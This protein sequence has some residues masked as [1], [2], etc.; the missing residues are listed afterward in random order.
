MVKRQIA[1]WTGAFVAASAAAVGMLWAAA[2]RPPAAAEPDVVVQRDPAKLSEA[3]LEVILGDIRK[4][5][6]LAHRGE[7]E[8]ARGAWSAARAR[9]KGYWPIH[10][11]LAESFARHRML[12]EARRELGVADELLGEAPEEYVR[13]IRIRRA[14]LASE[15]GDPREALQL[16][17]EAADP[18]KL[19]RRML[20]ALDKSPDPA[21]MIKFLSDQADRRDARL[22]KVVS[23]A[24]AAR[25]RAAEAAEAAGRYAR[26]VAPWDAALCR[27]AIED[28]R[29]HKLWDEAV[30]VGRAWAKA[31]PGEIA[32]YE[33]MGDVL[34]EAGRESDALLYYTSIVD[35][36]AG[37]ADAHNRLGIIFRN[38]GRMDEAL[39][40]FEKARALRP[41]EPF[42]LQE[43]AATHIAKGDFAAGDRALEEL[44]KTRWDSRFGDVAQQVRPK[45]AEVYQKGIDEAK[46][47]G[48]LDLAK[49][50]R[51]RAGERQLPEVGVFD[52]KVIIRWDTRADVDLDV[53]EPNGETVNHGHS[54][55]K[56][57]GKY[58][59]DN[60]K[61]FGPE[62]Y[63][64]LKAPRGA[65][66]VGAHLH[67]SER[68]TVTFEVILFEDTP[69][70]RR[71][72]DSA[73]LDGTNSQIW[74]APFELR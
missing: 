18:V 13:S 61:G 34:R 11:A 19:S 33:L 16:L 9:G 60:T 69:Q 30:A 64:I 70:E 50:L 28:L 56:D 41:E 54:V 49:E 21:A 62:H 36:R 15:A 32:M 73:I 46:A 72:K 10:E 59:Y 6:L 55:S 12:E 65:Y 71:W 1:A 40:Q 52:V 53:K 5:D 14:E 48:N 7:M 58:Y 39:R 29:R 66:V 31:T 26:G 68:S 8:A 35:V 4:G 22:W 57:G 20:A 24:H 23:T 17:V 2:T 37:D 25:G 67:G 3:D 27:R 44:L 38:I 43:I 63:T 45:F 74:L 42:W 51:R 47:K